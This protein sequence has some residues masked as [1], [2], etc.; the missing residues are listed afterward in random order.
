MLG[1]VSFLLTKF[2]DFVGN[3]I[4]VGNNSI[5]HRQFGALKNVSLLFVEETLLHYLTLFPTLFLSLLTFLKKLSKFLSGLHAGFVGTYLTYFLLERTGSVPQLTIVN[6]GKNDNDNDEQQKQNELNLFAMSLLS[7]QSFAAVEF[8]VLT[9][10]VEE[11]EILVAVF[12]C[13]TFVA[14]SAI[15]ETQ[16]LVYACQPRYHLIGRP[17]V[18]GGQ[19]QRRTKAMECRIILLRREIDLTKRSQGTSRLEQIAVLFKKGY[20]MMR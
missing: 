2:F 19:M 17:S 14:K 4:Q 5:D 10:L 11:I 3:T 9:R 12:I 8:S 7:Q 13:K 16:I 18:V 15:C 6:S 20:G 1:H